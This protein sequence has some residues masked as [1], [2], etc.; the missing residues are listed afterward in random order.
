MNFTVILRSFLLLIFFFLEIAFTYSN[1]S[2]DEPFIKTHEAVKIPLKLKNTDSAL[3]E[4]K[5]AEQVIERF[6]KRYQ[7]A[8]ASVAMVKDGKLVY[9]K[10][11]GYANKDT[12]E[13]VGP[14]HLF[15]IASVSKLVTAVA[16]MK[17]VEEEKLEI[18]DNVFGKNGILN[19]KI[20][21][22]IKDPRA[23]D[24]TVRH[25]LQHQGGWNVNFGDPMFE[26]LEIAEKM[27]VAPP[28]A[29][30][31]I[32]QY[33][34]AKK[35]HFS[36]GSRS[37]Y[38]NLGFCILGEVIAKVSKTSY[39]DYVS[40][41]VLAPLGIFNMKLGKNLFEE[42]AENE[43]CYYDHVG[44]LER[45]SIYGTGELVSR[46]YA[47]THIEALG[48][49]GGWIASSAQLMR[50]LVAID[51]MDSKS[52]FLDPESIELMTETSGPGISP[53]GWRGTNDAGEWWRTG[54][55]AGTSALV[56]RQ[57]D[58]ISYA[59][60]LNTSIYSGPKF[61]SNIN[62][63]METAISKIEAWPEQDLFNHYEPSVV[64]PIP[65]LGWPAPA[66]EKMIL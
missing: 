1:K 44:A 36:P 49:A 57:E 48:A 32:I 14:E 2:S 55:L 66:P 7:I 60:I 38:S 50:L 40:S 4:M 23:K 64:V 18:D 15:R 33:I 29:P 26:S 12:K 27:G 46:T 42:R 59:I 21:Q 56:M 5:G 13:E 20:Y 51:G 53:M 52:D 35:L 25:L 37:S 10:G 47:G 65:P 39:Q 9:T 11:F 16:I 19:D 41:K 6:L 22:D 61:T 43:V 31:T 45:L 54:T 62:R 8:G 63:M 17:L 34:L 3:E 24:I 58:G 30:A 28:A